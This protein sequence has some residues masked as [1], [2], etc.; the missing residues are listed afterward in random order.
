MLPLVSL[1]VGA[2]GVASIGA[3]GLAQLASLLAPTLLRLEVAYG[4]RCG[5]DLATAL[6]P[7]ATF[8]RLRTLHLHWCPLLTDVGAAAVIAAL[9]GTL[10]SLSLRHCARIG[11]GFPPLA[12]KA[13]TA[14]TSNDGAA[15]GGLANG[16]S[17]LAGAFVRHV[18]LRL[19]LRETRASVQG[20][21]R[22]EA[23]AGG[24][25]RFV[26]L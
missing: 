19:D 13:V 18:V 2:P 11:D 15:H 21:A 10:E 1:A 9:S 3:A 23:K 25:L 16:G 7:F 8:G 4:E 14:V 26:A 5:D 22:Y 6:R 24:R 12:V 17:G 20:C